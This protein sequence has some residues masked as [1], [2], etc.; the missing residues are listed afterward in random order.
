MYINIKKCIPVLYP[1]S[2]GAHFHHL[3]GAVM[4]HWHLDLR[5][6]CGASHPWPNMGCCELVL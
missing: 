5:S 2:K 4:D 1:G 6:A 3:P